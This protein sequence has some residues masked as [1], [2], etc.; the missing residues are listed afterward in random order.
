MILWVEGAVHYAKLHEQP[1]IHG[2][3]LQRSS[4]TTAQFHTQMLLLGMLGTSQHCIFYFKP[5]IEED[6]S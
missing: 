1:D 2:N 5:H 6:F 3:I 4:I